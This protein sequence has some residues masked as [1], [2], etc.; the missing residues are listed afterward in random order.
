MKRKF[1]VFA[2]LLISLFL[3]DAGNIQSSELQ[4]GK[5]SNISAEKLH[6]MMENKNFTLVNVHDT[7]VGEIAKTDLFIPYTE[8]TEHPDKLPKNKKIVVYC[9]SDHQSTMAAKKLA[10]AGYSRIYNLDGGMIDW[11]KAGYE[12]IDKKR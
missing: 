10:D 8:I 7:Y 4:K 9:R 12:V 11:E 3:L 2:F 1:S 6:K 5:Y